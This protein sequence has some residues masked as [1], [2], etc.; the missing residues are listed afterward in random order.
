L[1]CFNGRVVTTVYAFNGQQAF[2]VK[3][4][5]TALVHCAVRETESRR[6]GKPERG[7]VG[8]VGHAAALPRSCRRTNAAV[9]RIERQ[10]LGEDDTTIASVH[11]SV[12]K[13]A[14]K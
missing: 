4:S 9:L 1:D 14:R 2:L 13:T 12:L 5:Q 11:R 3:P 8:N 7:I 10:S 6:F